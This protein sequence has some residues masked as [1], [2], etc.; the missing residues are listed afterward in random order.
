MSM[1]R[2]SVV[3]FPLQL[4]GAALIGLILP[5]RALPNHSPRPEPR[6]RPLSAGVPGNDGLDAPDFDDGGKGPVGFDGDAFDRMVEEAV[7]KRKAAEAGKKA[8]AKAQGNDGDE[9]PWNRGTPP[10]G[11]EKQPRKFDVIWHGEPYEG[12]LREW[13]VEGVAPKAGVALISG[14]WGTYKTFIA[15]DLACSVMTGT[16]FANRTAGRQGGVL[17]LAAE[18]QDEVR[19]RVE[20]VARVKAA[21]LAAEQSDACETPIDPKRLPFAWVEGCPVLTGDEARAELKALIADTQCAMKEKFNLP[22]VLLVIDA[23]TSAALFRDANDTSEAARVMTMLAAL[24]RECGLLIAVIDHF[25][26][27]VTTG[28]R[29]SSAKED[30]ADAVLALLG[31]R[32]IEGVVSN[33]RMALRKVRGGATGSV[34]TFWV[35]TVDMDGE[36]TLVIRWP[37]PEEAAAP[38]RLVR[39]W[40]KSLMIFKRALDKALGDCGKRMRPFL[41]GPEVLAVER[42]TLRAE[43]MKTYP[44][45]NKK[46]QGEAFRR[47]ERDAITA[48]LACSREVGENV[49]YWRLDVK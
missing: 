8:E 9:E 10:Y 22:L 49:F 28:T 18:G 12:P 11:E 14:Q 1:L 7:G 13:L 46:A 31:E 41:D 27:D 19:V 6:P 43:F 16:S 44:A 35:E 3:P 17:F 42:D 40:P 2:N 34:T 39:L 20:A 29:N 36:D 38:P 45:D 30:N 5:G 21:P 47:C 32:S 26:K 15:L 4:P 48:G 37:S 33:P 25:G 23:M 24:G